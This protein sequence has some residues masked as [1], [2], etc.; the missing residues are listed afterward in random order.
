MVEIRPAGPA[1]ARAAYEVLSDV[2]TDLTASMFAS[3]FEL[4]R[5]HV[6]AS[7]A[8]IV[9]A[10]VVNRD[11]G[12]LWVAGPERRRGIGS[13]LLAALERDAALGVLHFAAA[14]S[15]P[16]A[17]PFLEARGYRR[18][19]E[20]WLLGIDLPAELPEPA[21]PEGVAVRTFRE[22]D[23][24]AVKTLLDEA[25]SDGEPGYV[26]LEFEAWRTFMLGDD[27]YD[28]DAWFLAVEG[29]ELVGA[30]LNWKEG[31][32]K[33][34]VVSP[35]RRRLG[36][37]KALM[38][39]TFREFRDRGIGRVTLKTDSTNPTQAVRLYEHLGMTVERTDEVFEKR[40]LAG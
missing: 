19:S 24:R 8:G 39:Q 26:P 32:V 1:E 21:W 17:G 22:D 13:R 40:L 2:E 6:A 7:E 12:R 20:I 3:I 9:G 25:Y 11:L 14:T 34:L 36:L 27:S 35:R 31:Y 23:A 15:E 16:G 30:A 18:V 10:G 5:G 38:L 29:D 33:D 37:G 28:A 4:G